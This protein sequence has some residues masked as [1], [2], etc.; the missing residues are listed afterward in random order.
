MRYHLRSQPTQ[1]NS[2]ALVLG[3]GLA[4]LL[5]ARV[6]AD[7]FH[8][9]TVIEQP[10]AIT[11]ADWPPPVQAQRLIE[12][13]FPGLGAELMTAGAPSVEWTAECPVLLPVGWS[14][15]FQSGMVSRLSTSALL[16]RIVCQ[17]LLDYSMGRVTF[18]TGQIVDGLQ[19]DGQCISGVRFAS[20]EVCRA[21]LVL[22]ASGRDSQAVKWL[23]A[24]GYRAPEEMVIESGLHTATA[25]FQQPE[26]FEYDWRAL[27]VL[28]MPGEKARGGFLYPVEGRRWAVVLFGRD[29]IPTDIPGFLDYAAELRTPLVA[30][31]LRDTVALS[32][33]ESTQNITLRQRYYERLLAWPEGFVV[34]GD[35]ACDYSA[36]YSGT[37]AALSASALAEALD[38]QR[39]QQPEGDLKG[40]AG[41]FLGRQARLNALPWRVAETCVDYWRATHPAGHVLGL[42]AWYIEQVMAVA[43]CH[44]ATYQTLLEIAQRA[45]SPMQLFTPSIFWQ[46]VRQQFMPRHPR[47]IPPMPP[48]F[49]A[50]PTRKSITQEMAA[51]ANLRE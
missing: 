37:G 19:R 27:L 17:R 39:K 26:G 7:H 21:D 20:G 13:W 10:R 4:G 30:N 38:E 9:V 32:A 35:A 5:A 3:T 28:P 15:R 16:E 34:V 48:V 6:L 23:A 42:P 12:R 49:R 22:E 50:A 36:L 18:I 8:Q 2:H 41:R 11:L 25:L 43:V 1:E 24:L 51:V 33:I 31:I 44:P 40:L 46:T 47:M 14:P 45:T 29:L